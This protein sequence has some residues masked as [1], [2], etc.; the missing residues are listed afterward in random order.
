A[1]IHNLK[2]QQ[3]WKLAPPGQEGVLLGFENGDTAYRILRISDLT[4]VVT[5][6]A[7]FN[8]EI[9]PTVANGKTSSIWSVEGDRIGEGH[10]DLPVELIENSS[11]DNPQILYD[12]HPNHLEEP[13][14]NPTSTLNYPVPVDHLELT[15]QQQP[16]NNIRLRII[17]PRHPT[18]IN[19]DV[20]PSHI[21]PYSRRARAFV[22]TSDIA[23][24]TY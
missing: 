20:D 21:L 17:G 9:F 1:V 6:N 19:S 2:R 13:E 16:E 18:L 10:L 12:E 5:R 4:V 24:R 11:I 3:D 14:T 15:D 23:P 22:T 8:E 7:T